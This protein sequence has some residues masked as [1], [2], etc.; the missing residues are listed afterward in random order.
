[1]LKGIHDQFPIIWFI[2]NSDEVAG[3]E[4]VASQNHFFIPDSAAGLSRRLELLHQVR[5]TKKILIL[6]FSIWDKVLEHNYLGPINFVWDSFYLDELFIQTSSNPIKTNGKVTELD[7]E[8]KDKKELFNV[9]SLLNKY[10][11]PL[12]EY[13]ASRIH[14]NNPNN[15][16]SLL[17]SR[18]ED[19]DEYFTQ[20]NCRSLYVDM[21]E[22]EDSYKSDY[23]LFR[24][25]FR[26]ALSEKA[27]DFDFDKAKGILEHIFVKSE[28]YNGWRAEQLPY[29]NKILPAQT[30]LLITL[31]TGGGKSVLFQGP[32]LFRSAFS[33]KLNIVI[34]P[35]KGLMEDQ[36]NYLHSKGFYSNVEFLSGD[37]SYAE[38]RNLMRRIVGGEVTLLYITPERFR[39]RAFEKALLTRLDS[40]Q[41]FEYIIYDE[42]H[43]ISQWGQDFRPDYLN[44]GK[45]I[46]SYRK[47]LNLGGT[48]LL[49]SAT[50][51]EQVFSQLK[52]ILE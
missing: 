24:P 12:L 52:K 3:L 32:A 20:W 17:D 9:Y 10:Q 27:F 8:E 30:D 13:F 21:W 25:H 45:R 31:P 19:P 33:G 22:N 37:K 38:S 35:L 15:T 1:L 26:R 36:V 49:F 43:C 46:T 11:L 14:Q 39:S 41:G 4:A 42:A 16:I 51:S 34:T 2:Q 6:P 47:N 48:T 18:L 29:L 40:D 44:A 23:E 5:K 28:G 7:E 50:I